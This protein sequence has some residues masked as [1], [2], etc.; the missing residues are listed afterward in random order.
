MNSQAAIALVRPDRQQR[1]VVWRDGGPLTQAALLFEARR[2]AEGL[3]ERSHVLNACDRRDGF[4]VAFLAALLRGQITV[5]PNDRTRRVTAA[6]QERFAGLYC[7]SD[8]ARPL[9]G[10]ETWPV[11]P[12]DLA[13][14]PESDVPR[15]PAARTAAIVFTS[16]STG[17]PVA[18]E[19]SL[20]V[21]AITARLIARRFGLDPD[22]PA[23]ILAT[24]P[25]QHM[26]GLETS[27][28]VP[29]WSGASVHGARPLYPADVAAALAALP[30][31]RV[32][33]TTPIH[34]RA[35]IAAEVALP[36]LQS[37]ISATAPLSP[38]LAG[39]IEAH[40]HTTVFEIFG[41]SEAG[42]IATR[43]TV[44]GARWRTCDGLTLSRTDEACF[45]D[46][47]H[48]P[49]PVPLQD[50]VELHSPQVFELLGRSEDNI[51]IAGKRTSLS[52]LNAMLNA[53]DGVT[54]G[55]FHPSDADD[56]EE[57]DG[58]GG[59]GGRVR[60]LA[61]FVVAPGRSHGE[62]KAAL[63]RIIDPTFMP[64]RIYLVPSLPRSDTGKLP[65]AALAELAAAMRRKQSDDH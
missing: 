39:R 52:G 29:L 6:L 49:A 33:V 4:M 17:D 46:A 65:R 26:Y 62:I 63:R 19:K 56:G 25:P 47:S 48:F 10:L 13:S 18:N 35:L 42:T 2:L 5:L 7:L 44:E 1:R 21:L 24:V 60:R 22:E 64:R 54:D 51:N 41:F 15:L 59:D 34:L 43:R 58:E 9:E 30:A 11:A 36:E 31:P 32:L 20:G 8:G 28:A 27:I 37:V 12:G 55:A 23:A 61:A 14:P 40:F 38:K 16:G 3:P 53:I 45:V 57:G 50:T